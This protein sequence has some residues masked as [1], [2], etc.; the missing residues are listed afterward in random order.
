[1]MFQETHSLP[2]STIGIHWYAGANQKYNQSIN[3]LN[4]KD[5][6]CTITKYIGEVYEG[7]NI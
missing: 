5:T 3:H 6:P 4:F 1:M 7:I 2:E